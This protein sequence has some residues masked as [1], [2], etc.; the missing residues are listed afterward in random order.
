MMGLTKHMQIAEIEQKTH[1]EIAHEVVQKSIISRTAKDFKKVHV[2]NPQ[3]CGINNKGSQLLILA[4]FK[5]DI[6]S[7][8]H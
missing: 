1:E 6:F 8:K 7:L 3:I 5:L 2:S 4:K